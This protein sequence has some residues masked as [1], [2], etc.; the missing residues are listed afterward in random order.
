[1]KAANR[2]HVQRSKQETLKSTR[3]NAANTRHSGRVGPKATPLPYDDSH[4]LPVH[5][6]ARVIATPQEHKRQARNAVESISADH[7]YRR[8]Q[9]HRQTQPKVAHSRDSLLRRRPRLTVVG[10]SKVLEQV[11]GD[12]CEGVVC[13]VR[14]VNTVVGFSELAR[15]Q[16]ES[17]GEVDGRKEGRMTGVGT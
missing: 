8:Q 9:Q 3:I 13:D 10:P 17:W 14:V 16:R 15:R 5:A 4:L 12:L 6:F 11:G 1:M 7:H 2:L